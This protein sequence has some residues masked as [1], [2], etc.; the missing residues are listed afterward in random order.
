MIKTI[1][2]ILGILILL[3]TVSLFAIPYFFKD[4][5]KAKITAT[6][7]KNLDATVAFADADLSLFK[8]FPQANVTI[9]KLSIINKAP[10]AGDTLVYLGELNLKMSIKELFK[11]KTEPMNIEAISSKNGLINIIY[12]K[13]GIGNFDIALKDQDEKGGKSDPLTLKIKEYN[14]ENYTFKYFDESS[15]IKMVIDSIDHSGT[16]D[17]A[18]S[19]L[20]LV[21]KSTAKMSL[22]MDKINYMNKVPLTLDAILGI[23]LDKS[24]YTFKE[25]KALVN[26]LP[27]EFDGFIQLVDAGQEYDLKFKTPTS[28][29]QNFL[30][31][32]PSTYAGQLKDVKTT[33]DFTVSGFAKGLYSDTTVPKFNVAIASNNASFKYPNLPKTVQNIIIDTKIIN[34]TG[35]LNDTYVNL[36]Q[37]SFKI[38]QDVFN[39]KANIRNI[40]A[41][42]LVNAALKGTI[43]LAN[44][45]KAYPIKMDQTLT[46]I[47]NADVVTKFDMQSVEKS[48]YENI[49]NSGT[50]SLSQF[51][52]TDV[53]G[54][55]L[56]INQALVQFNPSHV[57]LQ[58]FNATTGKSDLNVTGILE[59]FYGFMFKDQELKG[60][61]N[62]QSNQLLVSDFITT[63]EAPKGGTK[64]KEAMKIPAFLNCSLTAKAN[65]VIYDNLTLKDVSGKLIVKD[66]KVTLQ[67][68]KTSIFGGTIGVNGDVSTK[69]KTPVFNMD[70]GL[71]SVDIAQTFTQLDMLKKIAPIAGIINGKLNST[72]KLS[73]NLDAKEMTPDLKTITGD[74]LG[75]LLSTT[76]NAQNSQIL[77]ALSSNLKFIDLSKLNLNDLK[78]AISFTDGKVNVKPFDIKYQDI[79]INVG[80]SHGFDQSM[81]YNVKFDVPAKYMGPEVNKFIAKLSPAD[82]KK[83]ENVPINA[84]LTGNFKNPKVTTDMKQAVNNLA[85]QLVKQQKDKLINQGTTALGNLLNNNNP[86]DTT[87]TGTP[88]APEKDIKTQAADVIKGLFGKKKKEEPKPTPTPTP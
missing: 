42:P 87:K 15:K 23:D 20:D 64:T 49:D 65:T 41:N 77:T 59:N 10:F 48:Q 62:M 17:F 54:K 88:T 35:I 68:V 14:V 63:E 46:G 37:L 26:Q 81:N 3:L 56:H 85:T 38:D 11:G 75:Q 6:I 1:F 34:E 74:L 12:N 72:I 13:D 52:Y 70:L 57:N 84:V 43:N 80:G 58:Q 9:D 53:N 61:F 76:I 66:E 71:N 83:V 22:D 32:I 73:G 30:G 82:A 7:N 60:N 50:M 79:K 45:S 86:K 33:G 44:V 40:T 19:K 31:L 67:N 39:A 27:L 29:F 8:S 28:S 69:G 16:G 24:K 2:K 51:N 21:T 78:A 25:N 5:I 4:Q 55:T 18:S 47:L 36:D